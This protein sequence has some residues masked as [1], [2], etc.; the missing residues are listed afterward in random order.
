[1]YAIC[2]ESKRLGIHAARYLA[3]AQN[4]IQAHAY[5]SDT[6]GF[7]CGA[8]FIHSVVG[9]GSKDCRVGD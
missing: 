1:M 2:D 8:W 9:C 3:K 7:K 6:R 4:Q 5:Q